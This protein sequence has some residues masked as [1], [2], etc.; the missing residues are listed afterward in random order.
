MFTKKI[1]LYNIDNNDNGGG[2]TE[3][4]NNNN[5]DSVDDGNEIQKL[6][7]S[8]EEIKK[9]GFETKEQ[10]LDF[11]EKSKHSNLS[12][13]DIKK[14]AELEELEIKKFAI[15]KG[16]ANVEDF[17]KYN[18]LT[19]KQ[20]QDLVFEHHLAEFREDNEDIDDEET[21]IELA[22]KDFEEKYNL[23]SLNEKAKKRG[24]S[25]L[26]KVAKE[27]ISPFESKIEQV[28]NNYKE[29][30]N[31]EKLY[32]VFE[33]TVLSKVKENTPEKTVIFKFKD[34]ENEYPVEIELT[35]EDRK[36]IAKD[37]INQTTFNKFYTTEDKKSFEEALDKKMQGWLKINKSQQIYS[38][39]IEEGVKIGIAKG[40]NVGADNPFPISGG[41]NAS[42]KKSLD[43][44]IRESHAKAARL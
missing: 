34:G 24:L 13:E 44:E 6:E 1:V 20:K 11:F 27:L 14:Q 31:V 25:K 22:K 15:E 7:F 43:D 23:N 19:S 26:E 39:L 16:F 41:L 17:E 28:R 18:S 30:K 42:G 36:N 32:P 33:K 12:E 10:L 38:K 40:S 35:E 8:L 21:L 4:V 3:S 9:Y 2:L 5:S 29:Y 37:F